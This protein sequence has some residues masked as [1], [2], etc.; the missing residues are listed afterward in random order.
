MDKSTNSVFFLFF[1]I[2]LIKNKNK[3]KTGITPKNKIKDRSDE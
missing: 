2:T 1:I 3:N